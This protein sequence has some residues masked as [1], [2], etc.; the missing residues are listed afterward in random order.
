MIKGIKYYTYTHPE[1]R[2]GLEIKFHSNGLP[3]LIIDNKPKIFS[4]E[5]FS[6]W[7]EN[8]Y[9]ST[10]KNR[11]INIERVRKVVCKKMNIQEHSI[12]TKNRQKEL[13]KT[14]QIIH[15]FCKNLEL[16]SLSTIGSKV[17][18][19]DHTTVIH[20]HKTISGY[21]DIYPEWRKLI[22]DIKESL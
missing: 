20:S 3:Y 16:A 7:I 19:L 10:N 21:F 13:V 1:L 9:I 22:F 6:Y 2:D 4:I 17:G 5:T 15:Y 14:R 11:K 18:N 12:D 8:N